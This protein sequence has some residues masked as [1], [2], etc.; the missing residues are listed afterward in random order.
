M[1][2]IKKICESIQ[3]YEHFQKINLDYII[4]MFILNLKMCFLKLWNKPVDT[5]IDYKSFVDTNNLFSNEEYTNNID[6]LKDAH[7]IT[8]IIVKKMLK[9]LFDNYRYF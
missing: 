1:K 3:K 5:H 6:M 7:L 2:N 4:K 9:L 8:N